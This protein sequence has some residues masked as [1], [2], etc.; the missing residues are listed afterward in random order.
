MKRLSVEWKVGL[1][2]VVSTILVMGG[3]T[4]LA[5]KKGVFERG[6]TFTLFSRTGEGLSVGMPLNFSGFKIGKVTEL[7][8]N[9]EGIVVVQINVPSRHLKWLRKDSEFFLERPILGSAKLTVVTKNMASAPLDAASRPM[10][11]EVSDINEAIKKLE[12]LLAKVSLILGHVE[13]VTGKMAEKNS[14]LEMAVADKDA[15]SAVHESLKNV[16]KVTTHL[17]K[18]LART[19]MELYGPEGI[20]PAVIEV[21][22]EVVMN[23]KKTEEVLDN[24]IKVS[25]DAAKATKDL[26]VLRGEVDRAMHSL[27]GLIE[28]ISRKI[29]FKKEEK[30]ELP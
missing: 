30:V 14:L 23:L 3:I 27:N 24:V 26:E 1:F 8:L 17:D 22:K 13:R 5:Y 11:T 6:H 12:P 21:L 4:Y 29:P 10:I 7:E 25:V 16:R 15:V 18:I 28:E 20:K 9:P 2:L 19:E